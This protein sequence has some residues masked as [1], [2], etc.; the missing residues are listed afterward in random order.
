MSDFV[1]SENINKGPS[2]EDLHVSIDGLLLTENTEAIILTESIGSPFMEG[3]IE[4]RDDNGYLDRNILGN[5]YINISFKYGGIFQTIIKYVDGARNIDVNNIAHDKKYILDLVSLNNI[6]NSLTTISKAYN[7]NATD[8]I[9]S[10]F[11]D[12]LGDNLYVPIEAKNSGRY[13]APL[14]APYECIYDILFNSYDMND[15]PLFL[16][17]HLYNE[18]INGFD[19]NAENK[20]AKTEQEAMTLGQEYDVSYTKLVSWDWL[21]KQPAKDINLSPEF[22]D[23]KNAAT[24][25]PGLPK[26]IIIDQDHAANVVKIN[27]GVE[28]RK[29][30]T[31]N[32]NTSS[33][34]DSAFN[35]EE[36]YYSKNKDV[37]RAN[38]PAGVSDTVND[39]NVATVMNLDDIDQKQLLGH[40]EEDNMS[41]A[42]CVAIRAKIT[43]I[44]I[45]LQE[46][47]AVPG[48]KAGDRV[49][50]EIPIG[51]FQC[52]EEELSPKF[53]GD[54]WIVS[55]IKHII[56]PSA[57]FEYIQNIKI[58]R[59]GLPLAQQ[60]KN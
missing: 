15:S 37:K 32:A 6:S 30:K 16:Y 5:N 49:K 1:A 57:D 4:I 60:E 40:T 51:S 45:S 43:S 38:R 13:I 28:G 22:G 42:K 24:N 20:L 29:I 48:L 7:S 17:E 36:Q 54:N 21:I 26:K 8:V 18:Y 34:S 19:D 58:I 9:S 47:N 25:P 11:E 3:R 33:Y 39:S 27:S 12:F 35:L 14:K 53:S 46:C 23:E 52:G 41:L 56:R 55:E 10:I 50:F 59:D 44:Q 2:L 31:V